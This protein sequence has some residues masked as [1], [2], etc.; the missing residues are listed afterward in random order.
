MKSKAGRNRKNLQGGRSEKEIG[1]KNVGRGSFIKY[2]GTLWDPAHTDTIM[3]AR[4]TKAI[5]RERY[6]VDEYGENE[7]DSNYVK[8][9]M[10]GRQ[11]SG[12]RGSELN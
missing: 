10:L 5:C 6:F 2:S 9:P 7:D 11:R 3:A 12:K 4:D 1:P 8:I